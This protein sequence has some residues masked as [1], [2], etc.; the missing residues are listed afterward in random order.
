MS[1]FDPKRTLHTAGTIDGGLQEKNMAGVYE[2]MFRDVHA[3]TARMELDGRPSLLSTV[4]ILSAMQFLN[5]LSIVML[6]DASG[7]L[8]VPISREACVIGLL[9]LGGLN[10]LYSRR[11]G[12]VSGGNVSRNA[13]WAS[14]GMLYVV[15][16]LVVFVAAAL[17]MNS[18][19]SR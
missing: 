16:S 1:A 6:L 7:A 3:V 5:L 14:P 15:V 8:Q 13:K 17:Y 2:G 19:Y 10:Y 4:L 12:V 9:A 18:V 11:L